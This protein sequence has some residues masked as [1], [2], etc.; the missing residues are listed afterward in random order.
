MPDTGTCEIDVDKVVELFNESCVISRWHDEFRLVKTGE[1]KVSISFEDAHAII[2]RLH[3]PEIQS[4]VFKNGRTYKFLREPTNRGEGCWGLKERKL[5]VKTQVEVNDWWIW[6]MQ[7]F[8][9]AMACL[10]S[11]CCM[12]TVLVTCIY[13]PEEVAVI[14]GVLGTVAIVIG[15]IW[16]LRSW[17]KDFR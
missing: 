1:C 8:V 14:A 11:L 3:L 9:A 2:G 16:F 17:I 6:V 10:V 5:H 12:F 15:C 13:C 7:V 4:P